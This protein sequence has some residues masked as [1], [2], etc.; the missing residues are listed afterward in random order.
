MAYPGGPVG[1]GAGTRLRGP[2]Y[3]QPFAGKKL[4]DVAVADEFGVPRQGAFLND[5][6]YALGTYP[7]A[8]NGTPT[9]VQCQALCD[10]IARRVAQ[11]AVVQSSA[12]RFCFRSF[13][14]SVTYSGAFIPASAGTFNG[15]NL[16][17]TGILAASETV[18]ID[19]VTGNAALRS[20]LADRLA[21][22]LAFALDAQVLGLYPGFVTNA[23]Q[24]AN[25][26]PLTDAVIKAAA[27]E[28]GQTGEPIILCV[29]QRQ[30][31]ANSLDT[32]GMATSNMLAEDSP[33]ID[34][35]SAPEILAGGG[36]PT[37]QPLSLVIAPC[38]GVP[39]SGS[40]PMTTHNLMFTPSAIGVASGQ[41]VDVNQVL[42][43][44]VANAQASASFQNLAV[45]V[46]V[47]NSGAGNQTVY[48][49]ALFGVAVLNAARGVQVIS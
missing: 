15:V 6:F 34:V 4:A 41:M 20:A 22:Q 49:A 8:S 33:W 44:G 47:N 30:F 3:V 21:A 43:A 24:G 27:A 40:A 42:A 17:L 37:A 16:A 14:P 25:A 23:T 5:N 2:I 11:G 38:Q 18:P 32:T 12:H 29:H 9:N 46:F 28:I 39:T 48:A 13:V 36:T 26:T 35:T 1:P 7:G 45:S 19:I 10:L 31:L